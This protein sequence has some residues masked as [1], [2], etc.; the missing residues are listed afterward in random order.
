MLVDSARRVHPLD[1]ESPCAADARQ[2][3]ARPGGGVFSGADVEGDRW[4]GLR[5]PQSGLAVGRRYRALCCPCTR[6]MVAMFRSVQRGD[7]DTADLHSSSLNRTCGVPANCDPDATPGGESRQVHN[8][9]VDPTQLPIGKIAVEPPD[10]ASPS[11]RCAPVGSVYLAVSTDHGPDWWYFDPSINSRHRRRS[12][13]SLG[14]IGELVDTAASTGV[15]Q[16]W[17]SSS[18]S[19]REQ[20]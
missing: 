10:A 19:R 7:S 12:T 16:P 13:T 8:P 2:V 5:R 15:R 18:T 4:G 1:V 9:R 3:R 14:E 20:P 17:G 6:A 11:R